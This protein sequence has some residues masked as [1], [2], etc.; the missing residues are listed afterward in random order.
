[1]PAGYAETVAFDAVVVFIVAVLLPASVLL[2]RSRTSTGKMAGA[3]L[4]ALSV[5]YIGGF[6]HYRLHAPEARAPRAHTPML[7]RAHSCSCAQVTAGG[8]RAALID[9]PVAR[10]RALADSMSIGAR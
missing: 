9:S 5:L 10:T 8:L 3:G 4:L 2:L 1:M 6:E 7:Q